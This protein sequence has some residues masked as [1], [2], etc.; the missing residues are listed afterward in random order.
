MA[1]FL[2]K[3]REF[4][5]KLITG[6]IKLKNDDPEKGSLSFKGDL[7]VKIKRGNLNEKK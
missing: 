1:N 5:Q 2:T 4:K 3:L 7:D 6:L